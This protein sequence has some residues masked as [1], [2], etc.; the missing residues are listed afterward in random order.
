MRIRNIFRNSFFSLLSQLAL[1]VIGFFSQRAMNLYM[2]S[3]L[4]GMNGV[5]SN[6]ISVLS[7]TEL[8]VCTAIVYHLYGAIAKDDRQK[9]AGLMNLY[10][11]AYYIFAVIITALGLV[12]FPFIHLF[13]KNDTYPVSYIRV[14][15]MLW[16][17]RTVL[18]YLLSYKKSLLIAAQ[19]EYTVSIAALFMNIVNYSA[20]I[21]IVTNTQRY[22]L[23]LSLNIA[24]D[25]IV[26]L[27]LSLYVN[28]EYPYL[29]AV[30]KEK[31]DVKLMRQVAGDLKNI[32]VSKA[33]QKILTC[34]DNL[35]ISAFISVETVGLYTNYALITQNVSYFLIVLADTIQPTVGNLFTEGDKQKAY[36]TLRQLSFVFFFL[37]SVA[38]VGTCALMT[39]FVTDFWLGSGY[40]LDK[41]TV[42]LCIAVCV[43]QGIGLPL[44]VVINVTGLFKQERNLSIITAVVNIGVSVALV[45][46]LGTA[47]VLLGTCLAYAI[48]LVWRLYVFFRLY[49]CTSCGRYVLDMMEYIV[50][51]VCEAGAGAALVQAV[52]VPG[53]MPSFIFCILFCAAAPVAVNVFIFVT[54]SRM[55]SVRALIGSVRKKAA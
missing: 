34:T 43:I 19:R 55:R 46:P 51:I 44:L 35:I 30:K 38:A 26:N 52:Y 53:N 29:R 45:K 49:V 24:V 36:E 50:L 47:G 31:P 3:E 41:A 25:V 33:S 8:G 32:F 13:M 21:V 10:R 16:L 18:S 6:V 17:L 4:V 7:V 37:V 23:A 5:I 2:G 20:I 42:L 14:L 12:I 22:L 54:S 9:I 27:C 1:L 48:Q 11:K 28:R 15:Y 40:G 39:P